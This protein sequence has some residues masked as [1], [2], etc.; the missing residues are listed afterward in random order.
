MFFEITTVHKIWKNAGSGHNSK[1][2][3][4]AVKLPDKKHIKNYFIAWNLRG[5]ATNRER[6]VVARLQS[7]MKMPS[8]VTQKFYSVCTFCDWDLK[9]T[10]KLIALP[11]T[12][13][14]WPHLS[15]TFF[16][17]PHFKPHC[18]IKYLLCLVVLFLWIC[19]PLKIVWLWKYFN[20]MYK[21]GQMKPPFGMFMK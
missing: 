20:G 15:G 5:V 17:E 7:V 8:L 2:V 21:Y 11:F 14:I 9:W 3:F 10:L 1:I 4:L 12:P 6:P 18:L 19:L 13:K 16:R